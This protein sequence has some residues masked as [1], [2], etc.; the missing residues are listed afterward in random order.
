MKKNTPKKILVSKNPEAWLEADK[1]F[2]AVRQ[3]PLT[4]AER[5]AAYIGLAEIYLDTM[6]G[7]L[8]QYKN[9]LEETIRDWDKL[10]RLGK[11]FENQLSVAKVRSSLAGGK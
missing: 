11:D 6:N 1:L 5:G 7:V 8:L 4:K 3:T 10:T 2:T 9:S